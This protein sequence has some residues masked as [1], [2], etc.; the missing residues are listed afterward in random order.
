MVC[1]Y[2]M[3]AMGPLT[4]G[5]EEGGYLLGRDRATS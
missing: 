4:F 2:G 5:K 3:S 1:E